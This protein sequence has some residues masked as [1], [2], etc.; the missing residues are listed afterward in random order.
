MRGNFAAVGE[1]GAE[2]MGADKSSLG[3]TFAHIAGLGAAVTIPSK[4]LIKVTVLA[5][6]G[7]DSP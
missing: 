1:V 5:A 7:I 2:E 4:R 3:V 6:T